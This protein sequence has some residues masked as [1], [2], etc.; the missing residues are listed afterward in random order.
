MS[1]EFASRSRGCEDFARSLSGRCC[2]VYRASCSSVTK[3]GFGQNC[4]LDC[5]RRTRVGRVCVLRALMLGRALDDLWRC[6]ISLRRSA[7]WSRS[8]RVTDNTLKLKV[9]MTCYRTKTPEDVNHAIEHSGLGDWNWPAHGSREG[10]AAYL[11][12]TGGKED[13]DTIALAEKVCTYLEEFG[14][15]QTCA[16]M[17]EDA[18]G[19]AKNLGE[20]NAKIRELGEA[21]EDVRR[22][23]GS[24]VVLRLAL[25]STMRSGH[26][27]FLETTPDGLDLSSPF[28]AALELIGAAADRFDAFDPVLYTP[29]ECDVMDHL[30]IT[31]I[32]EF[33][34]NLAV[35]SP[36]DAND[37]YM[38]PEVIALVRLGQNRD[39]RAIATEIAMR[40]RGDAVPAAPSVISRPSRAV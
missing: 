33:D 39:V 13:L 38:V 4:S 1:F 15:P 27:L 9:H 40:R 23:F 5:W 31:R 26:R 22:R 10:F 11:L 28:A 21:V 24:Y 34:E 2:A 30:I 14:D 19:L 32:L 25:L 7:E 17:M 8:S 12:V 20:F 18:E 16:S 29:G 6:D 37:E 3:T 35:V 36:W